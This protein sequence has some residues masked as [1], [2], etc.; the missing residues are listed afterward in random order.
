MKRFIAVCA[1]LLLMTGCAARP[2]LEIFPDAPESFP[3][4][5]REAAAVILAEV[6]EIGEASGAEA[7]ITTPVKLRL[8]EC[9][10]GNHDPYD[11][12][13]AHLAAG[14]VDDF[15]L[16]CGFTLAEGETYLLLLSDGG[17]ITG[18]AHVPGFEADADAWEMTCKPLAV[19]EIYAE[20]ESLGEL[21]WDANIWS[22][23]NGRAKRYIFY[24]FK[25]E[26]DRHTYAFI[27]QAVSSSTPYIADGR[28]ID[29]DKSWRANWS[30][31][32]NIRTNT[33]VAVQAVI[34]GELPEAVSI[35][36]ERGTVNGFTLRSILP[37][38]TPGCRY[39][40]LMT[41]DGIVSPFSIV[42]IHPD[43]TFKAY[44]DCGMYDAFRTAEEIADQYAK[45]AAEAAGKKD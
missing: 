14:T 16:S 10:S 37:H 5:C 20:Y 27:G 17:I 42:K 22:D 15:T 23:K 26:L 7:S 11:E 24:D 3:A 29:P 18:G 9:Y 44:A 43:G 2:D 39:L 32:A 40:I 21:E 6:T 30:G 4:A 33:T 38:L 35:A 45:I 1:I 41:A 36:E 8:V 19:A 28:A 31:I 12:I 34:K 25:E 13:T